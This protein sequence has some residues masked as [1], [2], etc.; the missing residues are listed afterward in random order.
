[1]KNDP[2]TPSRQRLAMGRNKK[3]TRSLL[4][5]GMRRG[6]TGMQSKAADRDGCRIGKNRQINNN[7][8]MTAEAER[9]RNGT[10]HT[11][12]DASTMS[13]GCMCC[14]RMWQA[15]GDTQGVR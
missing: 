15:S 13:K 2:V 6:N 11:A 9:I 10:E 1:M 8:G 4:E 3:G 12:T 14:A 5:P 7:R